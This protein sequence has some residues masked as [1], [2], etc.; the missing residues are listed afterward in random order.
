VVEDGYAG[1]H[2]GHGCVTEGVIFG[3]ALNKK[4]VDR[5]R[6]KSG[7]APGSTSSS[8]QPLNISLKISS[9][10]DQSHQILYFIPYN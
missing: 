4:D 8:R 2:G 10:D 3:G 1:D 5:I 9:F 7:S 6:L